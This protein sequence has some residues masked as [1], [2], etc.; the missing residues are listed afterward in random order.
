MSD[1][2]D[3]GGESTSSAQ[4]R[5]WLT[6]DALAF[7][8]ILSFVALF[9]FQALGYIDIEAIPGVAWS[10]FALFVGVAVTWAFGPE[11]LSEWRNAGGN[12]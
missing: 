6:N 4:T 1:S 11:A 3:G 10:L 12:T 5:Y 9:Y 7:I 2:Q 8:L